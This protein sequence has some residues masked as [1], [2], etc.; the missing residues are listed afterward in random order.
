MKDKLKPLIK[1]AKKTTKQN[2][3]QTLITQL[4]NI[5]AK[6][7]ESSKKLDKKIGKEAKKLAKKFAKNIKIDKTLLGKSEEPKTIEAPKVVAQVKATPPSK[8][9]SAAE[10]AVTKPATKVSAS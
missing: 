8:Q 6:F 7:G 1:E 10:P 5:T 9:R 3:E 2:I 4:K